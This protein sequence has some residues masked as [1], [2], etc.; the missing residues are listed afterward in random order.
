MSC[1]K[2][3][4]TDFEN[5]S[6]GLGFSSI[7]AIPISALKGDNITAHSQRMPWYT[8]QPLLTYLEEP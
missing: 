3:I 7:Y 4:C 1:S 5:F 6:D 8:G 2:T